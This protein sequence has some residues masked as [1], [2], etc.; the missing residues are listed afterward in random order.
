MKGCLLEGFTA[1]T[2]PPKDG[3][4]YRVV[5]DYN[6]PTEK[7]SI[8][9]C[10]DQRREYNDAYKKLNET[11]TTY[12]NSDCITSNTVKY[13]EE[14]NAQLYDAS[15]TDSKVTLMNE[16]TK[17]KSIFDSYR[18][19]VGILQNARGPFDTYMRELEAEE[20]KLN[21]EYVQIQQS[22]RAGR[23]RFLDEDPQSGVTSILGLQTSDDKILLAFWV[24]FVAGILALEFLILH[25]YGAILQF[26]SVQ[27]KVAAVMVILGL[28][29]GIAHLFIRKFA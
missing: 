19:S 17:V 27:Q 24:C 18:E 11:L 14:I 6:L 21:A 5:Q 29:M 20:D 13:A 25:K 3:N 9:A 23:R 2:T 22:I 15:K 16:H 7:N 26:T 8:G 4:Y 12:K 28:S 10:V 1:T